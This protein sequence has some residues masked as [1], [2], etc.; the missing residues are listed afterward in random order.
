MDAW[1]NKSVLKTLGLTRLV[2][3]G[4]YDTSGKQFMWAARFSSLLEDFERTHHTDALDFK[5]PSP[6]RL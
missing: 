5:V 2:E 4:L 3:A 6:Q 1:S